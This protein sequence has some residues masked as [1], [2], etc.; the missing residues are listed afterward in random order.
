M[1]SNVYLENGIIKKVYLPDEQKYKLRNISDHWAKEIDAL[2]RLNGKKHFPQVIKIGNR[3]IWMT[4]CGERLTKDNLPKNWEQQ[5]KEIETVFNEKKVF[6]TDF[7]KIVNGKKAHKNLCVNKG[8][9]NVIDWGLW[10]NDKKE[11]TAK[12]ETITGIIGQITNNR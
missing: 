1:V 9:I 10:T 2:E 6:H 4:Y 12:N 3:V 11:Y 7:T 8:I 5:C